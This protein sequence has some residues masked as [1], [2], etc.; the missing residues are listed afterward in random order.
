MAFLRVRSLLS[1]AVLLAFL[2]LGRTSLGDEGGMDQRTRLPPTCAEVERYISS[3]SGYRTINQV[4]EM[5]GALPH[6]L[7]AGIYRWRL[8]DGL[9]D[10]VTMRM[11]GGEVI[12]CWGRGR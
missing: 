5:T 6:R 11:E 1:S 8:A 4:R 3:A 9:F 7:G 12:S 10:T 2:W